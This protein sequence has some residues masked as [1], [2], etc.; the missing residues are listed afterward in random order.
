MQLT[1][2]QI[3]QFSEAL[4]D[5]YST[6]PD[7]ERLLRMGLDKRL[8]D[9][10]LGRNLQ[11]IA[12]E[13]I[14][15]A[16]SEGW[17]LDLL[18]AAREG[19]AGNPEL[20]AFAQQL[21]AAPATPPPPEL[22]RLIRSTNSLLDLD[23][24]R[25][26]LAAIEAQVCRVE[27]ATN[28]WRAY[29][30]GFLLGPD[31]VITNYHVVEAVIAGERGETTHNRPRARARDV[32][33]RFDYTRLADGTVLNS[34]T[35]YRLADDWL[36]DASPP[37]PFDSRPG[38]GEPGPDELDY[39]LLRVEGAPGSHPIG[40]RTVPEAHPRGWIACAQSSIPLSPGSPLFIV[41]HPQ[42][43][44]LKLALDTDAVIGMNANGTRV[45]YRTNTERGSSGAPCFNSNWELVALHHAGDPN[46][47]PDHVPQYNQG[48][49]FA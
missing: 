2:T 7:L 6:L 23:P 27:V 24:W 41:Q 34:G 18:R 42:G 29:G 33:L 12:F 4:R 49:P 46:F 44:P 16:E 32:A 38:A 20:F 48:V 9:I 17:H 15:T 5:A 14:T 39:A 47:A 30:T 1:G 3:R 19:N 31:V 45:R 10:A 36:I 43:E 8:A 25:A 35:V 22:E 40:E 28:E 21:G 37:S 26:R 13:L 11:Q